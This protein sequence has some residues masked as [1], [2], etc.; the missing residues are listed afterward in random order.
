MMTAQPTALHVPPRNKGLIPRLTK[1]NQWLRSPCFWRGTWP[2]GRGRLTSHVNTNMLFTSAEEIRKKTCKQKVP[3]KVD[4]LLFDARHKKFQTYF[5]YVNKWHFKHT[6]RMEHHLKKHK[7]YISKP[8]SLKMADFCMVIY[9]I[10]VKTGCNITWKK[11]KSKCVEQ[12]LI[13]RPPPLPTL[14]PF[15]VAKVAREMNWPRWFYETNEL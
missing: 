7:Y 14:V 3:L 2:G 4:L 13:F 6:S 12:V 8:V 1:G 10:M 5:P 11:N 15:E 9:K